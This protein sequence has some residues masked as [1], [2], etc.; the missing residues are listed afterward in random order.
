MT[1]P[2]SMA[3]LVHYQSYGLRPSTEHITHVLANC[4]KNRLVKPPRPT[5]KMM[6]F[7][8]IGILY[9]FIHPFYIAFAFLK[10]TPKII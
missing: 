3:A 9:P 7:M 2:F 4:L 6:Q 5:Y 8:A 1:A 10:K